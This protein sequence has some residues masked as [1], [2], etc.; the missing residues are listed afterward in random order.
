[1]ARPA[2]PRYN[3]AVLTQESAPDDDKF[4]E[5]CALFGIYGTS[6]AAAHTALGLH[7]LQH[8]GQEASGIVTYDGRQFHDHRAAGL[9]GDIFGEQSVIAR[10]KG[11]CAIGHNRYATTGGSSD[12]NIQPIFADFDFGGLALAHNGNLTNAYILRKELVRMGCLFQS[13]TDTEVINHLIA[14]SN[15]STLV[16]RMIDALGRVKGAYS[17]L[18]LTNEALLG[19][20]D[21]MGVRPLCIG[22]LDDA[23]ILTSESCAPRHP[24]RALRARRRAG[25][26]RD[27]RRHRPALDQALHQAAAPL[28]RL[29]A[30]L[31]R[32][33]RQQDR[34]RRRLRG[35]QA[36]RRGARQGKPG[37]GRRHRPGARLR[38]AGGDRLSRSSRASRSS[39]ASSAT[40]MSAAPSSSR[41]TISAISACA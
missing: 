34:G 23:W 16:D 26:D 4:H 8:R 15:Y 21:P 38:R 20:R 18:L 39:S 5:E 29:R 25:R 30:H 37:A 3:P 33:A 14:R 10:L 6:D 9:V 12:R 35:A 32:P 7:A 40:T 28:L 11:Y 41:P 22:K 27:R 1:M 13:T 19:V 17:L 36:H 24:R 31:F 2:V